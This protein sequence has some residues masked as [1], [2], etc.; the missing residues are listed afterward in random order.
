PGQYAYICFR[1]PSDRYDKLSCADNREDIMKRLRIWMIQFLAV[2]MIFS[3]LAPVTAASPSV[4]TH[5][6]AS[7]L[8]DVTSG[9]I[10]YSHN[11]D[12]RMRIAS[13]TKIMTAIVAIE[14]GSLS[15]QVKVG[16]NAYGVEGSSIYLDRK[17]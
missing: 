6:Q 7:A 4:S 11:G 17:S 2:T 3:W 8:I 15:D 13:L 14:A 16:I 9:R 5:A 1:R 12:Q 10:L